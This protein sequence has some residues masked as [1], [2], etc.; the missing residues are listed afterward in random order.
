MTAF[1]SQELNSDLQ[2]NAEQSLV[3]P[4][5]LF[6][7]EV[8]N[9]CVQNSQTLFDSELENQRVETHKEQKSAEKSTYRSLLSTK[10]LLPVFVY[11]NFAFNLSLFI[12]FAFL[13]LGVWGI[14]RR[15]VPTLV[16]LNDGGSVQ[17][18]P[19]DPLMREPKAVKRFVA[20]T[21]SLL[22]NWSNQISVTDE[23][24]EK[25]SRD[26]GR[27]VG[28]A[29]ITTPAWEASF[30]LSADYRQS[31]LEK[32]S[33][34]IPPGVWS[35]NTQV[36]LEVS[37]LSEPIQLEPGTWQV[38][39]ISNLL[40]YRNLQATG[41][42]IPFNKTFTVKAIDTPDLLLA[43]V[44]TPLQ[45]TVNRIRQAHLEITHIEDYEND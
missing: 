31:F 26:P 27:P 36:V 10:N 33:R 2:I 35:G 23:E 42:I 13:G 4:E 19:V 20:Q 15:P 21:A 43:E 38:S 17:V 24:G 40:V 1:Q 8:E 6:D 12:L 39:Q 3:A 5:T 34:L 37:H 28:Q 41:Q 45:R 18:A 30:A 11:I 29:R 32:L 44:T 16:Q 9:Q 14:A 22:F 7:S 25:L